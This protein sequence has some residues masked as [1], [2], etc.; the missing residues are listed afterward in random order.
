[1]DCGPRRNGENENCKNFVKV[2]I[3]HSSNNTSV[4]PRPPRASQCEMPGFHQWTQQ[5]QE[6]QSDC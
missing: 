5:V 2:K 6:V 4:Y 1:M 3:F